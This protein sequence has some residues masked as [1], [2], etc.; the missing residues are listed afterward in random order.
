MFRSHKTDEVVYSL[1]VNVV[2]K[3]VRGDH[4]LEVDTVGVA[5]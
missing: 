1:E 2:E 4:E 3:I 5:L